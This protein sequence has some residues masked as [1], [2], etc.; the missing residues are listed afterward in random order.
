[1]LAFALVHSNLKTIHWNSDKN[2]T[3]KHRT[4]VKMIMIVIQTGI[5]FQLPVQNTKI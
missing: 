2:K 5:V 4:F 1:M 3:L